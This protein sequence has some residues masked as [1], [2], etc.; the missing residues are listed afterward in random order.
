MYNPILQ[1]L[2][3]NN[4]M[5]SVLNMA[6]SNPQAALEQLMKTSPQFAQFVHDNKGKSAEQIAKDYNIDLG[7]LSRLIR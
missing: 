4:N 5:M 2:N 3:T 7:M 1:R 6:K